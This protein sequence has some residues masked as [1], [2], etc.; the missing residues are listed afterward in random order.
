VQAGTYGYYETRQIK[1]C[2]GGKM[3][4]SWQ[5]PRSQ[6]FFT[7]RELFE[8]RKNCH[9]KDMN[10]KGDFKM[11]EKRTHSLCRTLEDRPDIAKG[12]YYVIDETTGTRYK[13][14]STEHEAMENYRAGRLFQ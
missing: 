5:K 12:M 11:D 8:T 4:A 9:N 7:G 13:P 6:A 3:F 10:T 2:A 14:A 1:G